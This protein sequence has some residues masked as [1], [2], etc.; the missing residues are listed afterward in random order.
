MECRETEELLVPYILG[1]L[2]S[3]ERRLMESHLDSC[4][5][6]SLTIQG[7]GETIASLAFA[8]PQ[9][10]VPSYVKERLF[11][12]IDA[13]SPPAALRHVRA[14]LVG[15]VISLSHAIRS[16][17]GKA[18]ALVLLVGLVASGIWFNGQMHRISRENEELR[19]QISALVEREAQVVDMIREQRYLTYETLWMTAP[20]GTSVNTLWG[21]GWSPD[22]QG[23][24]MF[25]QNGN[26]A[27]LVA[28]N[29]PSLPPDKVYKVW[30][31]KDGQKYG[32][33]VFTVDSTGFGRAVIIPV[34]PFKDVQAIEITLEGAESGYTPSGA[35][36]LKGDL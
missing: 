2:D 22:A 14:S 7:D 11:A 32:A 23:L 36:V 5:L 4:R 1:A 9:M 16:H 17:A 26:W 3:R 29:L 20:P 28:L 31:I 27:L 10:D 15:M 13:Q 18:A 33:G 12:R 21:M 24:M 34:V 30:L 8:V 25:P 6:C 35:S 19:N